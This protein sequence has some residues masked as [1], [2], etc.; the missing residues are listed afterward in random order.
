MIRYSILFI[1]ILLLFSIFYV[2]KYTFLKSLDETYVAN[3]NWEFQWLIIKYAILSLFSNIKYDEVT[4]AMKETEYEKS[5]LYAILYNMYD[6][7]GEVKDDKGKSYRFTFNTWGFYLPDKTQITTDETEFAGKTAY[8]NYFNFPAIKQLME[9]TEKPTIAELGCGTGAGGYYICER[10][11][12]D[13]TAIDMQQSAI[14]IL[15]KVHKH[16]NLKGI[17]TNAQSTGIPDESMDLVII[18]ETHISEMVGVMTIEDKKV[19]DEVYRILKPGGYFC[20]GNVI[21]D[22]TWKPCIKYLSGKMKLIS[23]E[24][25]TKEAIE[26]RDLEAKRVELYIDAIKD[27]LWV[28]KIPGSSSFIQKTMLLLKNF[29]RQPGTELYNEMVSGIDTYKQHVFHKLNN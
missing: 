18:N 3:T 10:M 5:T 4:G 16:K 1:F 13:Y 26:A 25:Y 20:W 28:S 12:C 14:N 9:S 6:H 27:K 24:D 17:C 7:I 8:A 15:N 19:F 21:P 29:Y 23:S 2:Q 22:A 11:D